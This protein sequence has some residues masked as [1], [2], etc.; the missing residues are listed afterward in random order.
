MREQTS[1]LLLHQQNDCLGPL[2]L[3]LENQALSVRWLR[4]CQE[5][6]PLLQGANPP[7]LVFTETTLPDGTWA[8]VFNLTLKAAK[9]VNVIVT[10]RMVDD[11]V[12]LDTIGGGAFDFIV[13]PLT[14]DELAHVV[15]CAMENAISRREA[16]ASA[17]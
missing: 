13:P 14:R 9:A 15:R 11:R 8:D 17:A 12:Y 1:V 3:A 10:A 7:H 5:A 6:G 4:N 2:I 16:Q